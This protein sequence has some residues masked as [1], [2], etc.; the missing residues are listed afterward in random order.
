MRKQYP[1]CGW[2]VMV[3]IEKEIENQIE[4][5]I[6][7][8]IDYSPWRWPTLR[9]KKKS[10]GGRICLDA[11]VIDRVTIKDACNV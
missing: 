2:Y 4:R 1:I 5:D 9:V 7:E 11:L 3:E 10:G 6:I 8:P